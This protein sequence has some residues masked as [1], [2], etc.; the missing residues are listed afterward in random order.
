MVVRFHWNVIDPPWMYLSWFAYYQFYYN[1]HFQFQGNGDYFCICYETYGLFQSR[2]LL[3][4][5][6]GLKRVLIFFLINT[7]LLTRKDWFHIVTEK[8]ILKKYMA[9]WV[10]TMCV[11]SFS[12][13]SSVFF[14]QQTV[15]DTANSVTDLASA[16]NAW[17]AILPSMA[18]VNVSLAFYTFRMLQIKI[19]WR[20]TILTILQ[21]KAEYIAIT[22]C[23][24]YTYGWWMIVR[25]IS[26]EL[27]RSWFT[28]CL[29]E[30]FKYER[31]D[32][33]S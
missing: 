17:V 30:E 23:I 28:I 18:N 11:Q 22:Y 1:V 16:A 19:Q 12:I 2:L 6:T 7:I 9:F 29:T 21:S 24:C 27:K 4:T 5:K 32:F 20:F 8:E 25:I 15:A 14:Q 3:I 33:T 26:I 10:A 31:I 13:S